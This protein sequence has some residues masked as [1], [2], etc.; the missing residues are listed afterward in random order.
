MK[1]SR[2]PIQRIITAI[3]AHPRR[4]IIIAVAFVLIIA[5]IITYIVMS[6]PKPDKPRRVTEKVKQEP[7]VKY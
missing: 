5:G 2:P 4:A 1:I 7:P 6:Q 3:K